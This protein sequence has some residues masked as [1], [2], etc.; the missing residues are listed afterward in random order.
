MAV[1]REQAQRELEAAKA[2]RVKRESFSYDSTSNEWV[3]NRCGGRESYRTG[4]WAHKCTEES[5]IMDKMLKEAAVIPDQREKTHGSFAKAAL[6]TETMKQAFNTALFPRRL[7][8][9]QQY[10]AE[11]IL[12][13]LARIVNGDAAHIDHWAD[14]AGYAQLVVTE[15]KKDAP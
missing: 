3:C 10:A 5:D 14:I 4:T 6:I 1:I 7:P 8:A 2:K 11:M 13:K 9:V 15:L 12:S